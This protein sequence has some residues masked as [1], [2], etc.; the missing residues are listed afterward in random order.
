MPLSA[1]ASPSTAVMIGRPMATT[2]PNAKR[3]MITAAS[4][5]TASLLV[6]V[7]LETSSPT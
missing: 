5:P 7:V 2:V 1:P 6:E 3:R 4:N